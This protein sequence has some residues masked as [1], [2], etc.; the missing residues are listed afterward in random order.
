MYEKIGI[1]TE[2]EELINKTEKEIKP[3][4]EQIENIAQYNSLKV[5]NA[6]QKIDYQ[7]Y[8]SHQPQVMDMMI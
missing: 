6:F 2:T 7:K 5:I 4:F 1:K 8:T 3:I